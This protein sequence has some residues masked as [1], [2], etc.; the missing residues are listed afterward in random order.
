ML[1]EET[2]MFQGMKRGT[3]QIKQD[4]KF[5]WDAHNVRITNRED[6]TLLSIT[7]ET[8][9]GDSVLEFKEFYVGHCIVGKYL[10]I[11]TAN[12]DGSDNYIYRVEETN[13]GYKTIILYYDVFGCWDPNNPI[14]AIGVY[15]TELVQKVYWVDGLNQPRVINIAKPEYK[16]PQEYIVDGVNLSGPT[17]STDATVQNYYRTNFPNG[18]YI[19]GSFDF[20]RELTLNESIRV[21]KLYGQGEF[22]PGTIQ[23]AFSYYNKYEQESNIWYT[24][25]IYY[26]SSKDRGGKADEKIANGFKIDIY[27]PD[28]QFE[29]IR[30]YSI[31]RTSL[32]ATP[33]VKV[34]ADIP[35]SLTYLS[36][37]EVDVDTPLSIIDTGTMGYTIDPTQLLYT[38]GE[39]LVANCIAQKDNTLFLGNLAQPSNDV[40][41]KISTLITEDWEQDSEYLINNTSSITSAQSTYYDYTPGLTYYGGGFMPGE[42]YRC[43]V[44][45]QYSNG[46]WSEPIFLGDL[47]LAS[48]EVWDTLPM[49][50]SSTI[51]LMGENILSK[52]KE[53]GV[54][55][56]RACIV[57]PKASERNVICQGILCP[58]IYNV[59]WRRND[60]PYAASSWFFRPSTNVDHIDNTQDIYH[61]ASIQFRHNHALFTTTNRGAEVQNMLPSIAQESA[62]LSDIST[63]EKADKYSSH[64][65]VDENIVT[66][67]S[68]DLEFDT[69]LSNYNWQGVR[70]E[71]IGLARLDAISGDIDIQTSSPVAQGDSPGFMHS[72]IGYQTRNNYFINGGLITTS[73]YKDFW[74]KKDT[75]EVGT[76]AYWPIYP[77]HRSGSLNNDSRRPNDK[78]T[79]SS[80]LL[81]KKIS[82]LKFFDKNI[83]LT[84]RGGDHST[85]VI[86]YDITTPQLFNSNEVSVLKIAPAYLK[87]DVPYFGNIDS[88]ITTS[89]DYK[90]Y[91]S[92]TP[93]GTISELS[94]STAIIETSD[95]VRMKYK[96]S[97]HLVF[98]LG[99]NVNEIP[100][101]PLHAS[102]GNALNDA[103]FTFPDWQ[104]TGSSDGS[105]DDKGTYDYNL[106]LYTNTMADLM[107]KAP[108]KEDL[109]FI[110]ERTV[111]LFGK[112]YTLPTIHNVVVRD[113]YL[114]WGSIPN[115]TDND[116]ELTVKISFGNF[117]VVPST[118]Y[119]EGTVTKDAE[120]KVIDSSNYNK[121]GTYMG[122]T[123]YYTVT[124]KK[125]TTAIEKELYKRFPGVCSITIK[126]TTAEATSTSLQDSATS[127]Y[128]ITQKTF[129]DR[130]DVSRSYPYLLIGNL[131]RNNIKN[132]FGG[133]SKEAL[134]QNLWFPAGNPIALSE[135]DESETIITVPFE[136]GDT[137]Y[138]RY[139]CL[140]TYPF[141]QEDEN[142]IIEIGSF[143][144]ETRVN[145]DGRCDRNRGQLSNLNMTPQN[146]NRFNEVYNQKDNFY[147]YRIL[148]DDFY[149]QNKFKTQVTWSKEKTNGEEIDTWANITLANTIDMDGKCGEVTAIVPWNDGLF[150]FQEK[151]LN[152]LM[153]NSRV[154]VPTADGVPIEISNGYKL[155]SKRILNS[156]IGCQN[157]WSIA[158]TPMGIYFIDA[159]TNGIYLFN[160]QLTNLSRTNGMDWWVK[161]CNPSVL[162][163]PLP[164]NGGIR[165]FYD[166]TYGD[167]YFTPMNKDTEALCYSE[168]LNAF[169]SFMS[170]N[171]SPAMFNFNKTFYSAGIKK[172]YS[173]CSLYK[174]NT[175][176]PNKFYGEYK[177]WSISFISNDNPL[178]TKVFDN[179]ELRADSYIDNVL[180]YTGEDALPISY[181]K[182]SNEYQSGTNNTDIRNTRRK[183]RIWRSFIPRNDGTRQRIR[184]PWAM[185]T[186]GWKPGDSSTNNNKRTIIHDVTVK[187]TI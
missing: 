21:T 96:S 113:G 181:I 10:V 137:W 110:L 128:K 178:Y 88:L 187:Y 92:L 185:I 158:P 12:E 90:L 139:D 63:A 56:V 117:Y 134:R 14:E 29:Y 23:Y 89:G 71:I 173:G 78:G 74:I 133:I 106:A 48:S 124:I 136:Y 131:I 186:L 52:L 94:D 148:D 179:I 40:Y 114:E 25:P 42:S 180:Q 182:A 22:S 33:L 126:E 155:D 86:T 104:Q 65:F 93:I 73:T 176:L 15:E 41:A 99:N 164:N 169:T 11:F 55:K 147:T 1:K 81:K 84:E 142:S 141:T 35:V 183:F 175:G 112:K 95:A 174:N 69:S 58:T 149:K 49:R 116:I 102:I 54:K 27:I 111:W 121:N 184:N 53:L 119:L 105:N 19:K 122:P 161:N 30:V 168:V 152:Q 82:N 177:P 64:F 79:R 107:A 31:H 125:P 51:R 144:C 68:P 135:L 9:T 5:L 37:G 72:M 167:I 100:L 170:Y 172:D 145:I 47:V 85:D 50:S 97:P 98:S 16:I 157:K 4:G 115:P 127:T 132:K 130:D 108:A 34:V 153:F 6:N 28:N 91:N 83:S 17:Y 150:C 18:F 171:G 36:E 163:K 46:K 62:V 7:N 60:T 151:A 38:G 39:S 77:W 129:G 13:T 26:I 80:V 24:T 123:Q 162:W 159:Y 76:S 2:H 140:K 146:F 75:F 120:G 59:G 87:S 32:D 67:H 101:L 118:Y 70:L 156:I 44:Q 160:G 66:F 138:S 61:G 166:N 43:G 154:Q 3:H 103:N 45:I 20:V 165:T 143:M 109:C 8:G 57:F